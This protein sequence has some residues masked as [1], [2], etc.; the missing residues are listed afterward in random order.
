MLLRGI[1]IGNVQLQ[2]MQIQI[3]TGVCLGFQRRAEILDIESN[4]RGGIAGLQMHVVEVEGH[5]RS[6]LLACRIGRASW[7][8]VKIV[9]WYAEQVE[10]GSHDRRPSTR[11]VSDR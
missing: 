6:P 5:V 11:N 4:C 8:S 3:E 7:R 1:E 9:A 10:G 2:P